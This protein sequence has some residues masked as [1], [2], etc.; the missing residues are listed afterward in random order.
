[1]IAALKQVGFTIHDGEYSVV[2]AI[3]E[4]AGDDGD[5]NLSLAEINAARKMRGK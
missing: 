1:M 2:D 3:L 5:G 4:A